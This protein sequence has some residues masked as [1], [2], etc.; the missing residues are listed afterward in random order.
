MDLTE[1]NGQR[2]PL[3]VGHDPPVVLLHQV[4]WRVHP[5]ERLVGATVGVDGD[6]AVGLHHDQTVGL[7]QVGGLQVR[8]AE[9]EVGEPRVVGLSGGAELLEGL[10]QPAAIES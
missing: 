4:I 5:V 7:G 9:Q 6:T 8:A 1:G 10:G 2:L 3:G